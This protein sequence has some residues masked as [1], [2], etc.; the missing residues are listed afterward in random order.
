VLNRRQASHREVVELW[1]LSENQATHLLRKLVEQGE[2]QMVGRGRSTRY[3]LGKS[4]NR[5]GN[6][7]NLALYG[8]NHFWADH[9][10]AADGN[11]VIR[12]LLASWASSV[13]LRKIIPYPTILPPSRSVNSAL[14]TAR[15]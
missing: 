2:L 9:N 7:G 3:K 1:D 15:V 8:C 5:L 4:R 14:G 11:I 12:Y 10:L 13:L 6:S